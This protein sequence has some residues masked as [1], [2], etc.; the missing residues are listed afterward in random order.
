MSLPRVLFTLLLS[1]LPLSAIA[2]P[3]Q[4]EA[5][6]GLVAGAAFI[7]YE[8]VDEWVLA[9]SGMPVTEGD[10]IR[11]DGEGR[12][13]IRVR[14][15]AVVRLDEESTVDILALEKGFAQLFMP[16][17]DLYA[18]LPAGKRVGLEVETPL[19]S[20]RASSKAVFRLSISG[21]EDAAEIAV[22]RGEVHVDSIRGSWK[23][24]TGKSLYLEEGISEFGPLDPPDEWDQW[25]REQDLK[26]G[27]GTPGDRLP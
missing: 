6:L 19:A 3:L 8:D 2:A 13:E 17:G 24:T 4:R 22:S 14:G 5:E 27:G 1:L 7:R 9:E 25:N 10:Q 23:V 21:E 26:E 18:M 12:V 20:L 15:G 11:V 16:E